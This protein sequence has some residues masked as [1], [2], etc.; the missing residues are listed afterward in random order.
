MELE[1][2]GTDIVA[3]VKNQRDQLRRLV[4]GLQSVEGTVTL[5]VGEERFPLPT[6]AVQALRIAANYLAHELTISVEP[7][8][9][10]LTTQQAADL[11]KVSRPYVIDLIE[12]GAIPLYAKTSGAHRRVRLSDVLA[13]RHRVL[14]AAMSGGLA[15]GED[16]QDKAQSARESALTLSEGL[17]LDDRVLTT[18]Q[19]FARGLRLRGTVMTHNGG[20]EP[21]MQDR[22]A[23]ANSLA[24]LQAR[25]GDTLSGLRMA[26]GNAEAASDVRVDNDPWQLERVAGARV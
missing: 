8:R 11:L 22:R 18:I 24:E 20:Q 21:V 6:A 10:I 23:A 13:Y 2:V 17:E 14:Q 4:T 12:R 15:P 9:P 7:Y 26:A 3:P 25:G 1:G 5:H 16:E 19:S